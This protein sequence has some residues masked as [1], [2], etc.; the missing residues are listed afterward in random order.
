MSTIATGPSPGNRPGAI[1]TGWVLASSSGSLEPAAKGLGRTGLEGF[2]TARQAGVG[3][4]ILMGIERLLA[5]RDDH[6]VR[7]AV[8]EHPPALLV[9]G[10][11]GNHDLIDDLL[12]DRRVEDRYDRL[13]AAVE[14]TRHHVGGADVDQRLRRR[15]PVTVAEAEDARVL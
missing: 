6:V 9:V 1:S 15:Q 11:V 3:H 5:R 10:E 4:E 8:R 13:D 14:V 12:V 7:T 2:S